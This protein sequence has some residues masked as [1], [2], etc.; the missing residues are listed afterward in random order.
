MLSKSQNA[1]TFVFRIFGA[2]YTIH[3]RPLHDHILFSNRALFIPLPSVLCRIPLFC[4]NQVRFVHGLLTGLR[5]Q[6]ASVRGV[7]DGGPVRGGSA[8]G[9]QAGYLRQTPGH[10]VGPGQLISR[11][12]VPVS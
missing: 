5:F 7:G 12:L 8:P 2:A 1:F 10:A 11:K 6:T 9:A 4:P 3:P